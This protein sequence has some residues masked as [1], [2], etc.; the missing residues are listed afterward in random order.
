MTANHCNVCNAEQDLKRCSKCRT[1]FYCSA[2]CQ[3]ADWPTHRAAC[4]KNTWYDSPKYRKCDDGNMHEGALELVTWDAEE[5]NEV[6]DKLGWGACVEE[7]SDDLKRKYYEEFKGDDRKMFEYWPQG[8]RWT[9]CGMPGD[10]SYGC[11][12]HGTGSKPCTCDYCRAG[13]MLPPRIYNEK[14]QHRKGLKLSRGPD[15]RSC[16]MGGMFGMPPFF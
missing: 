7:E 4:K 8:Y 2:R 16:G 1:A 11:D 3:T 12:H 14:S 6:G 13:K 15:P 9:C 5:V 10:M